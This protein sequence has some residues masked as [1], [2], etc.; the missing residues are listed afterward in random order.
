[1]QQPRGFASYDEILTWLAAECGIS[2]N[3]W[4]VYDL[5]RRRWKAKLKATRPSHAKQDPEAVE[6]FPQ[7]LAWALR[8]AVRVAPDLHL[9]YWVE[10][11]S[12][13][14]LKPIFRRRIADCGVPPV[15]V[16][17][18]QFEWVW[19]YGFVEPLSGE[20]F[21]WECSHLDHVCFGQVLSTFATLY[22]EDMHIVQLDQRTVHRT[23]KLQIPPNVAFYFQPPYS[24]E[25]NPIEQLWAVLKGRLANRLWWGLEDLQQALSHQL[26]QLTK[27]SLRSLMQ[28]TELWEALAWAEMPLQAT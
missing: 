11:E 21:F 13:F 25:L 1:M 28:R 24:P 23:P 12:R 19:L 2:V 17:H 27:A 20:S 3:Y 16:H 5:V 15:T 4:V 9:R 6:H 14:G 7:R 18:W 22:P 26:Q 8:K 10:D